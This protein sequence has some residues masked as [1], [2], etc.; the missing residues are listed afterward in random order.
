[1]KTLQVLGGHPKL[2]HPHCSPLQLLG[3]TKDLQYDSF[4]RLNQLILHEVM[5]LEIAFQSQTS[6]HH[7]RFG[8]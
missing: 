2:L 8:A 5:T 7:A 3:F 1:M 4:S 6:T